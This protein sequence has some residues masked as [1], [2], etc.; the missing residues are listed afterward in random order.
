MQA[1][2]RLPM[3]P[4]VNACYRSVG[5]RTILSKSYRAWRERAAEA[6]QGVSY[7]RAGDRPVSVFVRLYPDSRRRYDIDNRT[8]PILDLLEQLGVVNND[9]QVE[10][11]HIRKHE[12]VGTGNGYAD[13]VVT[14][15]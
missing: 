11:L 12:P 8:K 4:S 6:A 15:A 7:D 3:P 13:V 14:W 2:F 1:R 9:S 10:R 5:G